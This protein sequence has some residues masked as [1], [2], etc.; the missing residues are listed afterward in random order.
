MKISELLTETH[1]DDLENAILAV[2]RSTQLDDYAKRN[3]WKR[4][5]SGLYSNVY[6]VNDGTQWVIKISSNDHNYRKFVDAIQGTNNKHFPKVFEIA[7]KGETTTYVIEKLSN[8]NGDRNLPKQLEVTIIR[9]MLRDRGVDVDIDDVEQR[10]MQDHELYAALTLISKIDGISPT[11]IDIH[12]ENVMSRGNTL[13]ITD[14][15]RSS[16]SF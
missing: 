2:T 5:G 13:V 4:I 9:M 6:T 14:P 11:S 1:Q 8:Y 15:L 7:H 16:M 3:K 12:R 10:L